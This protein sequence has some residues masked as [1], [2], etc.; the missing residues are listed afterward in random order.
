MFYN[1]IDINLT[2]AL[3]GDIVKDSDVDAIKN[4][5]TNI[6]RTIMGSRVMLPPFAFNGNELLFEPLSE[7]V[8]NEVASVIWDAINT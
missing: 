4:S 2:K 6:T 3:T 1:D 7:E 8:A 5:L